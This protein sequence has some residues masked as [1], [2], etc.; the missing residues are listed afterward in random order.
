MLVA[1]A[2]KS[3]RCCEFT[4][5][6]GSGQFVTSRECDQLIAPVVEEGRRASPGALPPVAPTKWS[7]M[8]SS[9]SR[10][11]RGVRTTIVRHALDGTPPPIH[12]ALGHLLCL[13]SLGS[14]SAAYGSLHSGSRHAAAPA[15][16]PQV[17]SVKQ[18]DSGHVAAGPTQAL[19]KTKLDWIDGAGKDEWYR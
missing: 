4:P 15:A 19:D 2:H 10:S 16:S 1:V 12:H 18:I 8:R 11:E 7:G 9:R 6:V 17:Q 5:L 3:A 14:K 13:N